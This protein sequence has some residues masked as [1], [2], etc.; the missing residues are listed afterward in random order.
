MLKL[1]SLY[2]IPSVNRACAEKYNTF[3]ACYAQELDF[4]G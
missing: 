4:T 3:S 1:R 2:T